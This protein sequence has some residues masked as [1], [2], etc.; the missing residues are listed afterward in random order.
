MEVE[1]MLGT[2]QPLGRGIEQWLPGMQSGSSAPM[3]HCSPTDL[4]A[5]AARAREHRVNALFV[6]FR[7]PHIGRMLFGN[8]CTSDSRRR[9]NYEKSQTRSCCGRR[10]FHIRGFSASGTGYMRDGDADSYEGD[11]W[12]VVHLLMVP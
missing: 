3:S 6:G 2:S 12:S 9:T 5:E 1:A 10:D 11:D 7:H 8:S 4:V